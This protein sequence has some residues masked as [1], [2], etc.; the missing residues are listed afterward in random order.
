GKQDWHEDPHAIWYHR[1]T[2]IWQTVWLESVPTQHVTAINW[3]SDLTTGTVTVEVGLS[4]RADSVVQVRIA[5]EGRVLGTASVTASDM[6]TTLT[7]PLAGQTNGQHYE[8][9][10]WRPENPVLLDAWVQVETAGSETDAV[11]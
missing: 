1:T 11:A 9:L 7:F 10:L 3:K 5:H 6:S 2:G 8:H 4:R